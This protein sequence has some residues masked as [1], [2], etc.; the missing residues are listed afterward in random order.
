ML[1]VS[2]C[3]VNQLYGISPPHPQGQAED[4]LCLKNRSLP[5]SADATSII[6]A[7]HFRRVWVFTLWCLC[8]RLQASSS[9]IIP[10]FFSVFLQPEEWSLPPSASA[11]LEL[12][13]SSSVSVQRIPALIL[14]VK[15]ATDTFTFLMSVSLSCWAVL[16]TTTLKLQNM[17]NRLFKNHKEYCEFPPP[18]YSCNYMEC[19]KQNYPSCV[20][21]RQIPGSHLQAYCI[22]SKLSR[23]ISM[24]G[25]S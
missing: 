18:C 15:R 19:L 9:R 8:H 17:D 4:A 3:A 12:P 10:V 2:P 20:L 5:P 1:A 24:I 6:Q 23:G 16:H 7:V 14:S 13:F 11:T 21:K 25:D 22:L